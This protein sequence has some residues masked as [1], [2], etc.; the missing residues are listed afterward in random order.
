MSLKSKKG[1]SPGAGGCR[2]EFL[3]ALAE[4]MDADKMQQLEEFGM[5]YLRS[6]LPPWFYQVFLSTRMVGLYKDIPFSLQH[7]MKE[8]GAHVQ[9]AQLPLEACVIES[10]RLITGQNPASAS[11]VGEKMREQLN[12]IERYA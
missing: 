3:V 8:R 4:T 2:A 7:E 5:M 12:Y 10:G 1:S 9:I 11:G 6:D